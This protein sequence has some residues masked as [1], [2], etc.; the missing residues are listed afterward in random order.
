MQA[1]VAVLI[2]MYVYIPHAAG[3]YALMRPPILC[4]YDTRKKEK[5]LEEIRKGM[6]R[7]KKMCICVYRVCRC[8]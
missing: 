7:K 2:F 5:E 8:M 6:K 4:V 3:F 1:G